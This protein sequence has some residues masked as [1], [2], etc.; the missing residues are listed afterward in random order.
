MSEEL[1]PCP[2]CGGCKI[3]SEEELNVT[4]CNGCSAE[5]DIFDWN[6]RPIEDALNARIAELEEEVTKGNELQDSY[7]DRIAKL[8]A[9][10]A[11]LEAEKRGEK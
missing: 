3:V 9:Y 1:K 7:C 4:L 10:V 8:E 11:E 6:N 2:F 5:T